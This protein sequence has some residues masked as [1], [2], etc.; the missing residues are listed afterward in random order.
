MGLRLKMILTMFMRVMMTSKTEYRI[1]E[2]TGRNFTYYDVQYRTKMWPFWA[3]AYPHDVIR[4]LEEAEDKANRDAQARQS[5]KV[6][7]HL[8]WLPK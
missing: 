5:P 6:V 2:K 7:K 8:G 1:V 3:D 4:T